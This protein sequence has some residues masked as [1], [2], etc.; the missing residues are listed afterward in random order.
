MGLSKFLN[1][2]NKQL[3]STIN[4]LSVCFQNRRKL[5]LNTFIVIN[6]FIIYK[7][8]DV[9]IASTNKINIFNKNIKEC[10]YFANYII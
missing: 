5:I 9:D 1:Q 8:S 4:E 2:N 7:L 3:F 10:Q 6:V